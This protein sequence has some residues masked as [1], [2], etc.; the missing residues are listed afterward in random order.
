MIVGIETGGTKVLCAFSSSDDPGNPTRVERIATTSPA[1]TFEQINSL[2][3][4][5]IDKRGVEAVGVASFG[6]LVTDPTSAQFGTITGTTK[7]GWS[8]VDVFEWLDV[9]QTTPRALATDVSGAAVGEARWG[10]AQGLSR[11]AYAT[12]G[13][14]VGVG[15][16]HDRQVFAGD[17]FPEMG[18]I[19]VRRHPDDSFAGVCPFHGDCV[20]GL[21]S[22]P[23]VA[24]RWGRPGSD[25]D[26]AHL[27]SMVDVVGYYVA[28]LLSTVSYTLGPER[29]V[30]GGGVM[31]TPGLLQSVH[32]HFESITGGRGAGHGLSLSAKELIV[33]PALGDRAGAMG[34]LAL[35]NQALTGR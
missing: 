2:I 31:K 24:A 34:A 13:T 22:G 20:E 14:G 11:V 8:N 26:P 10:A 12:V 5:T 21:A 32:E 29:I 19:L 18:N 1:E 33:E 35:A 15:F 23:A 9:D 7:P 16:L 6:P 3:R 17:G 27:A 25:L 4:K 30:L 28:Q